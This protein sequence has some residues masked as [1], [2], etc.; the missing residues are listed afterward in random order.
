MEDVK[1]AQMIHRAVLSNVVRQ[2]VQG[3]MVPQKQRP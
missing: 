3:I 1:G 2:K